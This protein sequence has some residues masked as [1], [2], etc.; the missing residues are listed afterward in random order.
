MA[1]DLVLLTG[2]TGFIGFRTLVLLLKAGYKVR[3][4]VRNVAGFEKI[5]ALK[6]A[7]PYASQ[8]QHIIVPDITVPGAYDDAV[9]G[10]YTAGR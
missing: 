10:L 6:S 3:T 1:G 2:A 9:K 5:K 4:A 8:I 7:A